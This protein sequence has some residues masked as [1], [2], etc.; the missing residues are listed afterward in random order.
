MSTRSTAWSTQARS[1]DIAG[2]GRWNSASPRVKAMILAA[3]AIGIGLLA[4]FYAVVAGAVQRAETSRE[5]QRVALERQFVCS[6]FSSASSRDLCLLTVSK[7]AA[8]GAI[9]HA[10]YEPKGTA[11]PSQS[12]GRLTAGL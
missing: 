6:A 12:R 9:V 4:S 11:V 8:H 10:L 7:H 1:G 2:S 3:I 5:Q